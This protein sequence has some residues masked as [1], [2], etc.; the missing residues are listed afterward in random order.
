MSGTDTDI[1]SM[2]ILCLLIFP[3]GFCLP[4]VS[5]FIFLVHNLQLIALL[6]YLWP[7]GETVQASTS[8]RLCTHLKV[9][10]LKR[11]YS[12]RDKQRQTELHCSYPVWEKGELSFRWKARFHRE[13]IYYSQA[14]LKASRKNFVFI[15]KHTE[16]PD[17]DTFG[18]NKECFIIC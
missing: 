5:R 9:H 3:L 8:T 13:A 1:A 12:Y 15:V 11:T 14:N 4:V 2:P 17:S 7:E 16:T 18:D 6:L 10:T